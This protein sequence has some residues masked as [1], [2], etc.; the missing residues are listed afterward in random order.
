MDASNDQQYINFLPES[1]DVPILNP[2][3]P[4]ACVKSCKEDLELLDECTSAKF[5]NNHCLKSFE[6]KASIYL[7]ELCPRHLDRCRVR[8][9]KTLRKAYNRRR[10]SAQIKES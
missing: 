10:R 7:S 4:M 6:L 2:T 9:R 8:D 1:P 5:R 3:N